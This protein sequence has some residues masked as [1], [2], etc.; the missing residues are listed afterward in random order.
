VTALVNRRIDA[1]FWSGGRPTQGINELAAT[2]P[3]RLVDLKSIIP[4][5]RQAYPEYAAGTVPAM[6][7]GIPDPV[8]T[9]LVRNVLLVTADMPDDLAGALVKALFEAQETLAQ[10]T[11]IALTIDPRAAIGTQPVPLHA[12]AERFYR[13]EKDG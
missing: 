11:P 13:S 4:S 8:S 2:T 9:L 5:A 1:F 7:Y 10:T 12:G 6:S 3:I